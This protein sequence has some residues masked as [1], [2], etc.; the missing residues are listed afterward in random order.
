MALFRG[1]GRV[2]AEEGAVGL[3]AVDVHLDNGRDEGGVLGRGE[4]GYRDVF[5]GSMMGFSDAVQ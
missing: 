4:A 5:H 3:D 2:E 1:E